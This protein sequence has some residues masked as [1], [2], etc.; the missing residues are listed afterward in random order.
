VTRASVE[1]SKR[2]LIATSWRRVAMS[3]LCPTASVDDAEIE[4][5]DRRSR[6][7]VAA[8]PV[9][10]EMAAELDGT[11][12][13]VVLA[14]RNA[15]L[16]DFRFGLDRLRP[17]LQEVGTVEGRRFREETTGTNS[18]ATAFE[19]RRGVA[20][21]GEEHFIESLK[22]FSCYGQTIIH[23]VTQRVEGVLDITCLAEDDNPLLAPFVIRSAGLIGER[24]LEQAR[25]AERRAF[26]SFQH[27]AARAR[28]RPVIAI[29]DDI[30]LANAAAMQIVQ[31]ADQAVLRAASVDVPTNHESMLHIRL[32][33]G[34]EVIASISPVPGTTAVVFELTD[35]E[36]PHPVAVSV[37][38]RTRT[39][40][41]GEPGSGRTTTAAKMAGAAARWLDCGEIVELGERDWF[42]RLNNCLQSG[43]CAVIESV[44]TLPAPLLH[45]VA[46]W[47]RSAPARVILTSV[48]EGW[49][50]QAHAA[51][52]AGCDEKVQLPP[53][54]QRRAEIPLLIKNILIELD[55]APQLRFTPAA[56]EA[57]ARQD[58]PGNLVE[59]YSVVKGISERRRVGDVTRGD[60]P[61]T[62]RN[63]PGRRLSPIEQAERDAI[64]N[65]L[66][67]SCGNKKA[68]A[69]Q[70]GIS[71]TTL[72]KALRS[73]GIATAS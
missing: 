25:E 61:A 8:T 67:L 26:N 9:L 58:W 16:T 40:I 42:R 41:S 3:G 27:A 70:L 1:R 13:A 73:Y 20:V 36:T 28:S 62:H 31:P 60:L 56:L 24:L 5:I 22:R 18:I 17:K 64:A 15:L 47:I 44:D 29:G 52:L 6:L 49:T 38:T 68:A 46:E 48:P 59:L 55:A 19:L 2:P 71:R 4:E 34:R 54:R 45:R 43:T 33:S 14:D 23:P 51:L 57:L 35:D 63:P 69:Q 72:Y 50:G 65:A 37:G 30:F 32:V 21:R 7:M 12:F 11:A 39:L 66:R 53:L 10:D